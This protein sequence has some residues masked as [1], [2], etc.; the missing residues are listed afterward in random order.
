ME[1]NFRDHLGLINKCGVEAPRQVSIP[2]K[3][4]CIEKL[5]NATHKMLLYPKKAIPLDCKFHEVGVMST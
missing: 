4:I 3:G 1:K 2:S 5:P